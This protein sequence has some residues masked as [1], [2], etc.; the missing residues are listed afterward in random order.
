MG[1]GHTPQSWER[2]TVGGWVVT[3]S[4][5]HQAI[6]V[7]RI[8]ALLAGGVLESPAGT[9]VLPPHPA[10]AAGPDLRQLVL[11]SEG[12][13]GVLTEVVV[14]TRP[15]PEHDDVR[16][17]LVP[18][19]DAAVEAARALA[20]AHLPLSMI[21]L[22]TPLETATLFAMAGVPRA[23]ALGRRWL[24]LRGTA[25]DPALLIV[26]ASGRRRIVDAAMR[27]AAGVAE[28][29]GAVSAPGA[30]GRRWLVTRYRSAG[31]RDTLWARGYGVDTLETAATWD[32]LPALA[33]DIGRGLRHGLEDAG[34]RVHAFS[35]LSHV[36][37]SGSSLY[38]TFVFR[39]AGDPDETLERWRRLKAIASEAI[40]RH[41]ATISHQHGV[42]RDHRPYLTAEKGELGVAALEAARATFD[43]DGIL[44]PDVLLPDPTG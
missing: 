28:G 20:R 15:R 36:Y 44:N 40:V 18:G 35:H 30:I 4:V 31:L 6:G 26:A 3:R 2:A 7:G 22:S 10:S 23:T 11:G 9:T 12:R 14:R 41:G 34:E 38:T 1:L 27:E 24:G 17:W 25:G 37:A 5:G 16:T 8:D 29:H 33:A 19:W 32:R 13:L 21:R 43:P 42:G 39:L